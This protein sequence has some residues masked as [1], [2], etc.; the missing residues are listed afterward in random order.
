MLLRHHE[1][2][3]TRCTGYLRHPFNRRVEHYLQSRPHYPQAIIGVL[4]RECH[5][6]QHSLIADIGS[7]TGMLA[8]LFLA[9]GYRVFGVEPDPEM[10]A[11]AEYVLGHYPAFTS[12]AA[13]AEA[14]GLADRSVDVVTAEQAFHWFDRQRARKEFARIWHAR[15]IQ[16]AF[17]HEDSSE[18]FL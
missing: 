13:S 3:K 7:G 16:L 12:I 8:A 10:H 9:N 2:R 1:K 5:L 6:T 18:P 14:T 15:H 4:K 17:F 11:A